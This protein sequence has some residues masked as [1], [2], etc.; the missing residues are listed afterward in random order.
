MYVKWEHRWGRRG[1]AAVLVE[2]ARVDGKPR[3]RHIAYL[4]TYTNSLYSLKEGEHHD[5]HN[6]HRRA[7]FWHDIMQRL[8]SLDLS[9][10]QRSHITTL[11]AKRLPKPTT[12]EITA[13]DQT[14]CARIRKHN[15]WPDDANFPGAFLHWPPRTRGAAKPP[16]RKGPRFAAVLAAKAR[17]R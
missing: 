12:A 4:A 8:A 17:A 2:S 10:E 14:E 7:W 13:Y 9:A 16:P 15:G 6:V 5:E 1:T 11:V 3:Q